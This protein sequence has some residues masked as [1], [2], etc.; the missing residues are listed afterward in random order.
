MKALIKVNDNNKD[1]EKG[2]LVSIVIE[3]SGHIHMESGT[4]IIQ[5]ISPND[6]EKIV[7]EQENNIFRCTNC[8]KACFESAYPEIIFRDNDNLICEECSIDFEMD[9]EKVVNR[10]SVCEKLYKKR[11]ELYER[12]ER[13]TLEGCED[14]PV[15]AYKL[16]EIKAE[17]EEVDSRLDAE[18][19]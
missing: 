8:G 17:L 7:I 11:K 10:I 12:L 9:G 6:Y 18:G 3:S 15:H 16:K 19:Y 5:S 13:M 2:G 4:G 14:N 1:Y